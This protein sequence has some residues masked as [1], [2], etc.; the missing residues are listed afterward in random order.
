MP[1]RLL[2][3][4]TSRTAISLFNI[5]ILLLL[6][7]GVLEVAFSFHFNLELPVQHDME[8]TLEG[9]G[10]ILVALG[11]ALEERETLM[12]F[13]KLYPEGLTP[14]QELVD[15]HCHGYG[16]ILLLLGLLVEV[17]VY[18]VKMPNIPT[19]AY[20]PSLLLVGTALCVLSALLVVRLTWLLA[21]AG[22][23]A[24]ANAAGQA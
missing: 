18:I 10:T 20:D 13:L 3:C 5:V 6:V 16:L 2:F 4:L 7:Q 19:V 12:K 15:H 9:L 22:S 11:V 17:V 21:R 8:E 14:F 23:D 1:R 24:A